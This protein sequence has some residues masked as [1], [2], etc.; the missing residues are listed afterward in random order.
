M[1]H[2]EYIRRSTFRALPP[3]GHALPGLTAPTWWQI[4]VI[5]ATYR[6]PTGGTGQGVHRA[7]PA[8]ILPAPTANGLE[9]QS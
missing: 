3:P 9:T 7:V 4:G 5:V 6:N 2:N 8:V 1:F